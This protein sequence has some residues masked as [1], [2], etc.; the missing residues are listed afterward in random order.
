MVIEHVAMYVDD[1]EGTKDFFVRYF[2]AVPNEGY[3][4]PRSGLRTYF[5]SFDDGTRLEIMNLPQMTGQK[6]SLAKMGYIHMA[7]SVGSREKVD[8]LTERLYEAGY[9]V[10]S[11]PRITGDGYYESLILGPED[12]QIEITE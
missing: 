6:K 10:I 2:D 3:H 1:L 9:E 12:N 5:L 11:G 4:N 8:E 7:F